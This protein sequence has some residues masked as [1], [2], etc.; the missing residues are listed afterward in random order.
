MV[1]LI[2]RG[3]LVRTARVMAVRC[4]GGRKTSGILGNE[5][6]VEHQGTN[7]QATEPARLHSWIITRSDGLRRATTNQ[8]SPPLAPRI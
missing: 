6:E 8:L 4:R 2:R 1:L 7:N 5:P 3:R